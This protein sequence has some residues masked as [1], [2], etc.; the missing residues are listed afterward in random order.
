MGILIY[1]LGSLTRYSCS[2]LA[3]PY[4][5]IWMIQYFGRQLRKRQFLIKEDLILIV[6]FVVAIGVAGGGHAYH[7]YKY[8]ELETIS[9]YMEYNSARAS[10]YDYLVSDYWAY[11]DFFEKIG[12]SYNDYDMLRGSM[13]Y[14]DFFS[15]DKY[16]QIA[17]I[18]FQ[19][20]ETLMQKR[21][22]V[23]SRLMNNLMYYNSGVQSGQRN[24]FPCL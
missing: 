20:N 9:D 18:N 4:V 2:L 17:K 14:D 3:L 21:V 22:A 8:S 10:A 16:R 19:E 15:I 13:I 12:V 11:Y 24:D 5:G 7:T 1:I 6:L 23:Q